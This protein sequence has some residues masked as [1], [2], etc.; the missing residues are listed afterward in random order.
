MKNKGKFYDYVPKVIIC[1]FIFLVL[2]ILCFYIGS[3]SFLLKFDLSV[4][5]AG[6]WKSI[7]CS[8]GSVL[9]V[10]GI[11]NVIYEFSI[12]NSMFNVIRKEL[13]I[14]D[15]IVSAGVDSIWLQLDDIPY[16]TLFEEVHSKID[17]L[18]SYGNSWNEANFDYIRDLLTNKKGITI[19][20]VLLSP[21]SKLLEGLYALY[22]KKSLADLRQSMRKS[23]EDWLDLVELAE[24]NNNIIKLYYHDQNPTHSLYCFD[25][26]IVNVSNMIPTVK[27]S[28]LPTI[29][30]KK[31]NKFS[32][33]LFSNYLNE[34]ETVISDFSEEVTQENMEK[35]WT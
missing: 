29:I 1:A 22:R 30:C 12:R 14:K 31:N 8:I 25:D 33:T 2:S 5:S 3:S 32:D 6:T 24:K 19:R 34:I 35:F 20:V 10:S 9:I 23:I 13:G 7:F 28:K 18:H 4:S 16:R 26:K 27:T 17:I 21:K 11:Y 15:F